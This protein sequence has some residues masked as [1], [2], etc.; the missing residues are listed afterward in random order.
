MSDHHAVTV[1]DGGE[2]TSGVRMRGTPSAEGLTRRRSRG[3]EEPGPG[4]VT[5]SA[6]D[7]KD[8]TGVLASFLNPRDGSLE[9]ERRF[10]M[11]CKQLR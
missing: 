6:L 4:P 11:Y 9:L 1:L 7:D 10:P 5:E 2:G 3:A 8:S